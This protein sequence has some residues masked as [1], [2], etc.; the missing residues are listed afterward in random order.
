MSRPRQETWP[1][2]S[3]LLEVEGHITVALEHDKSASTGPSSTH[4]APPDDGRRKDDSNGASDSR[5]GIRRDVNE[6]PESMT[7]RRGRRAPPVSILDVTPGAQC[8]FVSGGNVTA[9]RNPP[10][11]TWRTAESS[12]DVDHLEAADTTESAEEFGGEGV[13]AGAE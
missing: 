13:L 3:P 10:R 2:S 12:F 9:A 7:E 4:P 6:I 11:S 5:S 1:S 8:G